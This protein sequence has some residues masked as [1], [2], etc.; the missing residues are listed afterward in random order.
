M[1]CTWAQSIHNSA[2]LRCTKHCGR[3]A[4]ATFTGSAEP[5]LL[6][7]CGNMRIMSQEAMAPGRSCLVGSLGWQ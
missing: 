7:L 6:P 2:K 4:L 3:S 5:V 1:F